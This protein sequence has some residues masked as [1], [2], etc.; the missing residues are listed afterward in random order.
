MSRRRREQAPFTAPVRRPAAAPPSPATADAGWKQ[1]RRS[2]AVSGRAAAA[3]LWLLVGSGPVLAVAALSAPHPA[4]PV[5]VGAPAADSSTGPAGIAEL[6]L[7]AYL[8]AGTGTEASVRVYYPAFP[9]Q[10]SP[11][12]SRTA[13]TVTV[14]ACRQVSAGVYAVELGAHV[15]ANSGSGWTD[16]GEHYFQIPIAAAGMGYLAL[17]LPAEVA[18]PAA[19]A[20][21]PASGYSDANA[22]TSGTALSDTVTHFLLAY[23]T[24]ADEL[25]RYVPAGSPLTSISPAP[26]TALTLTSLST[27]AT[28]QAD[29][30]TGVPAGAAVRHVLAGITATDPTGATWQLSY[31]LT[32]TVA[33]GQW[34]VTALDGAPL[35]AGP[36]PGAEATPTPGGPALT[37][38]PAKAAP[39]TPPAGPTTPNNLITGLTGSPGP[40]EPTGF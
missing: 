6:Y 10:T 40:S 1:V 3:A 19:L 20:G 38:T 27:D 13:E 37:A 39:A 31:A 22:P 8:A 12:G 17:S 25:S 14:L 15:L 32:L 26:Y 4:A 24:G 28:A 11:P 29:A 34:Q 30:G 7:Q 18:A 16:Q 2:T 23:L 9:A 5:A 36:V 21:S 35:L 33:G